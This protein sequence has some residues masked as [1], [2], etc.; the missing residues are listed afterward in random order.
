MAATTGRRS[1]ALSVIGTLGTL[2]G[3]GYLV[4]AERFML[5]PPESSSGLQLVGNSSDFQTGAMKFFTYLGDAGFPD[6]VYVGRLTQGLVAYDEH[7]AHLQC[8]VQWNAGIQEFLCPCHGSIYNI[9]GQRIGGPAPHPLNFHKVVE[10]NGKVYVGA[11]IQWGTAEW[12][13]MAESLGLIGKWVPGTI[14]GTVQYSVT[15]PGSGG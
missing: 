8:P 7:C 13:A 12:T 1:F 15:Q 6:G 2:I 3:L 14:P 10:K 9:E 11:I 4:V 5:P